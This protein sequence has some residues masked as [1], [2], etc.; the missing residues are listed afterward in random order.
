MGKKYTFEEV[1]GFVRDLGYELLSKEYKD[2]KQKLILKDIE[3]YLYSTKLNT[4]K[5][6]SIPSK[7]DITN[8]YTIYNI[9][10]WLKL[11]NKH[12]ILLTKEYIKSH[13]KLTFTNKEGYFYLTSLSSLLT[14]R[15][16]SRFGNSNPYTIQNI[17]LWCKINKKPFELTSKEYI[18]DR[19]DEKLLWQCLNPECEEIFESSWGDIRGGN[20]CGK[21]SGKQVGFKNCLATKNPEL[22]KEWHPTLNGDLTPY[23]FTSGSS[24]NKVWWLCSEGH[25][26]DAFIKSR[27]NGKIRS[28]CPECHKFKSKGEKRI[29]KYLIKNGFISILQNNFSN[30]LELNPNILLDNIYIPQKTFNGLIGVGNGLLSYDFYIP[31]YSLL[32]EFQGKQHE[33][34]V[35]SFHKNKK[36][37]ET[38]QEHDKRKKEYARNNNINL[39]EIWYYDFNKIEIILDEY[40]K[41]LKKIAI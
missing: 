34:Y 17:G 39:L 12:L 23:D 30:L 18:E 25:E 2:N 26:W 38:Q 10:L 11:N 32:I 22:A 16:P 3:G 37:F 33:K 21:C 20:N 19:A 28:G 14:N 7:F 5:T 35:E 4:L 9:E 15:Y 40:I 29:I 27:N 1:K 6:G 36:A 31:K 24:T 13:K 41:N 8:I